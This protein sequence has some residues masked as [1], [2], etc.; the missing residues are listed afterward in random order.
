MRNTKTVKIY[1]FLKWSK[2]NVGK[3]TVKPVKCYIFSRGLRYHLNIE[4][5]IYL[6]SRSDV[7]RKKQLFMKVY[8]YRDDC[9]AIFYNVKQKLNNKKRFPFYYDTRQPS[10][11]FYDYVAIVRYDTFNRKIAIL[12]AITKIFRIDWEYFS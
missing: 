9:V 11:Y 6:F 12:L 2:E 10:I 1:T 5:G 4:L 8:I 3:K 7:A